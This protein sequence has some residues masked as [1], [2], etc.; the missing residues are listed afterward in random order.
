MRACLSHSS[1]DKLIYTCFGVD[2]LQSKYSIDTPKFLKVVVDV[3]IFL[4]MISSLAFVRNPGN[5]Y[6]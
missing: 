4:P 1:V 3:I 6:L 5:G 2:C